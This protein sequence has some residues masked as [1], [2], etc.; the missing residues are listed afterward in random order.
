MAAAYVA[1]QKPGEILFL[2]AA[3]FSLAG[4]AFV[5][6][7]VMGIFSKRT[8]SAGAV[9]GMLSGLGITVYYLA[10][11]TPAVRYWLGL[12]PGGGLWFGILPV[13]AGVFGVPVGFAVIWLVSQFTAQENAI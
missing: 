5:P 2:V 1:A 7:M 9:A 13:S 4:A 8:T 6:A 11:N 12:Q 3:S 10:A